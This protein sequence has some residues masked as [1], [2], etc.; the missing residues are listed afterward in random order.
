MIICY[1]ATEL[2]FV[3]AG[4]AGV[5][6]SPEADYEIFALHQSL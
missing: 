3:L 6:F 5:G 4:R 1:W 2:L